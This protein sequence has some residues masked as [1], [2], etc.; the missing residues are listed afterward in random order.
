[1]RTRNQSQTRILA[2][3]WEPDTHSQL[4][5]ARPTRLNPAKEVWLMPAPKQLALRASIEYGAGKGV[6]RA[7]KITST[8][9]TPTAASPQGMKRA[10]ERSR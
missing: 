6:S 2:T 7:V 1:V 4:C 3:F 5:L 9:K 8:S 10:Q